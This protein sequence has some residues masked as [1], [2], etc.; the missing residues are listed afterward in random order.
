MTK[1][2]LA[3]DNLLSAEVVLVDGRVVTASERD[4]PDLFWALRGG[5][6]NLGVV[7]S[8]EYRL[9]PVGP[10]VTGG[11]VA[12][13]F[14]V[15][16][17]ELRRFRDVSASLPD[18]LTLVAGLVHAPDESGE[19]MAAIVLC[20]CGTPPRARRR[21]GRSGSSARRR[22]AIG[23]MPYVQLNAMLDGN[24]PRGVLNYWKSSFLSALTDDA[25]RAMI[26]SFAACPTPMAQ[27]LMEHVHGDVA[28]VDIDYTAF[29]HRAE[30][31]N[32]LV[33]SE[34]TDLWQTEVCTAWTQESFATL[35]PYTSDGHYVSYLDADERP[36]AVVTGYGPNY[37]AQRDSWRQSAAAVM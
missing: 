4:H 9:H 8:F 29:P 37:Q 1:H 5:G 12:W 30:G 3:L 24:Y 25:I 18:E 31:Y 21:C 14:A 20:H 36:S 10:L 6:G 35:R 27:L 7:A 11:V 16:W 13:P 32:M 17:D 2:G 23:P 15:P 22:D 33:L 19:K 26:E 34:R 28:C